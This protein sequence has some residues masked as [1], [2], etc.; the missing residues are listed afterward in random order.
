MSRPAADLNLI[1][2][3][4]ESGTSPPAQPRWTWPFETSGETLTSR[5]GFTKIGFRQRDEWIGEFVQP[6]YP[7]YVLS[8]NRWNIDKTWL[9]LNAMHV[10]HYVV[11]EQSEYDQYAAALNK[12]TY[13]EI[14]PLPEDFRNTYRGEL[15]E[16]GGGIP[17]RNFIWEHSI[18]QGAKR[19]WIMDDNLHCFQ[20]LHR[21]EK[22]G[23][24]T[25][26]GFKALEDF[27]DRY[28]NVAI[29]GPQYISFAPAKST[30]TAYR[31]NT[32]IYSCILIKND[33]PYRWR[34]RYNE[35]TDLSIRAL[36][37]GWVTVLSN[38]FLFDKTTT[39]R[40]AGGNTA[41]LYDGDGNAATRNTDTDGRKQMAESLQAQHPDIVKVV[42]KFGRWQHSV[43][44]RGFKKNALIK[45][46][47][48]SPDSPVSEYGLKQQSEGI[49]KSTVA[50]SAVSEVVP[51]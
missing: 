27:V 23:L 14:L 10:P 21:G 32:R 44:Y 28:T 22:Q 31:L 41:E 50:E 5:L 29:A 40:N 1:D 49:W 39:M 17:A 6:T 3:N 36:K 8:K 7:I 45:V 46:H 2:P 35:D 20:R 38:A 16:S 51:A 37:D 47:P 42:R 15:E 11:V 30:L 18:L 4:K 25:G 12:H 43:D 19:H 33:I 48:D 9:V 26:A 13:S 34:G 24:W